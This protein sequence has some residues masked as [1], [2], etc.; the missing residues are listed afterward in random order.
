MQENGIYNG[1]RILFGRK[2]FD[3]YQYLEY[4]VYKKVNYCMNVQQKKKFIILYVFPGN[5]GF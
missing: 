5:P 1:K 3:K 2:L 4:L